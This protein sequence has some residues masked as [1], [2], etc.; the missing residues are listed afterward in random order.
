MFE[1][2]KSY[3][4]ADFCLVIETMH[5]V[6]VAEV[7]EHQVLGLPDGMRLDRCV[8]QKLSFSSAPDECFQVNLD[9]HPKLGLS[10]E[11]ESGE[12]LDAI[13]LSDASG[14]AVCVGMRSPD[15]M[16]SKHPLEILSASAGNAH[17]LSASY[18]VKTLSNI[19]IELVTAWTM[20]ALTEQEA[21]SPWF[22]VDRTLS[23]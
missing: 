9:L 12:A 4:F 22:A 1:L 16:V 3:W 19:T 17:S 8:R 2:R 14:S 13:V 21:L 18:E 15:W 7:V 20:N 6:S 23:F 5:S 11:W 10:S